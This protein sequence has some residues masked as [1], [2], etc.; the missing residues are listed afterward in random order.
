[1]D[2]SFCQTLRE[3]CREG[4]ENQWITLISTKR[5]NMP[6]RAKEINAQAG[7]EAGKSRTALATVHFKSRYKEL[8]YL[9]FEISEKHTENWT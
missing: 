5:D 4:K 8:P 6:Q 2:V 1:M 7:R 3:Y 9:L